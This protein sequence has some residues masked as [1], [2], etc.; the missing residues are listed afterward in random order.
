MPE[1]E[2]AANAEGQGCASRCA[3]RNPES[4]RLFVFFACYVIFLG[5]LML[6]VYR[7]YHEFFNAETATSHPNLLLPIM[8]RGGPQ[9]LIAISEWLIVLLLIYLGFRVIGPRLNIKLHDKT[10]AKHK[11]DLLRLLYFGMAMATMGG[12][13]ARIEEGIVNTETGL[14][15]IPLV[16]GY[17]VFYTFIFELLKDKDITLSVGLFDPAVPKLTL[18]VLLTSFVTCVLVLA[19]LFLTAYQVSESFFAMYC[20]VALAGFLLHAFLFVV[21]CFPGVSGKSF[22]HVHHWYWSVPLAHLC[23]FHTD[24]SML[25]QAIFLA[26]HM[27]GVDCFGVEPLFYDTE[28][29]ARHPSDFDWILKEHMHEKRDYD[30]YVPNE[31]EIILVLPPPSST[32]ARKLSSPRAGVGAAAGGNGMIIDG[33]DM[34]ESGALKF[35]TTSPRSPVNG[36]RG[37]NSSLSIERLT[38]HHHAVKPKLT[39]QQ[40]RKPKEYSS[41]DEDED[42]EKLLL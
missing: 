2:K 35:T 24:V 39:S 23:V 36:G 10:L 28:R 11:D 18:V 30:S 27:H 8:S 5:P 32:R 6:A 3:R 4:L 7:E 41:G 37:R 29:R 16:V 42:E 19:C 33:G 9:F 1:L 12:I 13:S 34:L 14:S 40:H 31:E 26:V 15:F 17:C 25:S 20:G 38:R 21:S 22:V